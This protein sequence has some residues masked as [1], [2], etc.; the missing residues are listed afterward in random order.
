MSLS[1]RRLLGGTVLLAA[2]A[3][4][5]APTPAPA[6]APAP[7]GP[8]DSPGALVEWI[9]ANPD[10]AAVR[11]DDGRG[12]AFAHLA[13]RPRPIASAVKVAH[14]VAYAQAVDAGRLDPAG[15]VPVADWERW[16]VA[17]ADGGAHPQALTALGATPD[18]TV[19]WDDLAAVMIDHSDNAA[20]DMLADTLGDDALRAAAQAGG[21]VD[22]D[23]AHIAGEGLWVLRPGPADSRRAQAAELGRA[24]AAGDADARALAAVY[25][26]GPLPGGG[27]GTPAAVPEDAWNAVVEAW[28]GSWAASADQLAALHTAVATD[29]LGPTVSATARRHLERALTGSLPPGV[30][31]FGQKGGSLPGIIGYAGTIRREDGTVGVSVLT[32][33]GLPQQVYQEISTSGAALL[34]QQ[35]LVDDA[36]RDRLAAALPQ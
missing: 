8:V 18:G 14:L 3:A 20:A 16:Y 13:G 1:R 29:A 34:G 4:C 5:A 30:L 21:W 6:G 31:G 11:L 25:S 17:G 15:A 36:L 19:T 35:V 26:G 32:L 27:A 10:R 12:T 2:A 22:L 33:S 7:A 23:V 28:D 24:F 9:A